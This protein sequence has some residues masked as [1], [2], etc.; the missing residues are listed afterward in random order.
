MGCFHRRVA[1]CALLIVIL[2][3][4]SISVLTEARISKF[5]AIQGAKLLKFE[6]PWTSFTPKEKSLVLQRRNLRPIGTSPNSPLANP[7][8][9]Q[10]G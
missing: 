5:E 6:S 2:F 8:T 4:S 1:V 3:M 7:S 10:H 9:H